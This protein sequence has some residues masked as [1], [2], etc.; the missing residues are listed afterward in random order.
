M[1]LLS[2][3]YIYDGDGVMD[4]TVKESWMHYFYQKARIGLNN[5]LAREG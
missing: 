3:F 2:V 5:K 4:Y 1:C